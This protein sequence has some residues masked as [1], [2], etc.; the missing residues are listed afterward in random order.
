MALI[1]SASNIHYPWYVRIIF[2]LQRRKYGTELEPARLWGRTPKVF[3]ALTALY[4]AIDRK[5]S[6]IEPALR[7]LISVRGSTPPASITV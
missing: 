2:W 6:P 7:S 5:T 1:R 4:R 3:L